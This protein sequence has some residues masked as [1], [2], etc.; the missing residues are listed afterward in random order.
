MSRI[1]QSIFVVLVLCFLGDFAFGQV[2]NRNFKFYNDKLKTIKLKNIQPEKFVTF[3]LYDTSKNEIIIFG[4]FE[5]YFKLIQKRHRQYQKYDKR[6][7]IED[8]LHTRILSEY[9]DTLNTIQKENDTIDLNFYKSFVDSINAVFGR[10]NYYPISESQ[11]KFIRDILKS[12]KARVFDCMKNSFVKK[13]SKAN[14]YKDEGSRKSYG[15]YYY[16]DSRRL[17]FWHFD[18]MIYIDWD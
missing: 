14:R 15:E 12:G 16:L 9:V 5:K 6:E 7:G 17:F 18:H 1:L 3:S 13:I 8:N 2:P 11:H 10:D 4:D